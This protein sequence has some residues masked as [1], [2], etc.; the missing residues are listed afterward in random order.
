MG[1][2]LLVS[3]TCPSG[4]S[5]PR[6]T[7]TQRRSASLLMHGTQSAWRSVFS[8]SVRGLT[9]SCAG[10]WGMA[11]P[12]R[13]RLVHEFLRCGLLGHQGLNLQPLGNARASKRHLVV[14]LELLDALLELRQGLGLG[15]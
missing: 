14:E 11:T 10:D 6:K 12:L 5:T 3:S 4:R 1:E 15:V 2:L 7:R 13:L 9:A 8:C